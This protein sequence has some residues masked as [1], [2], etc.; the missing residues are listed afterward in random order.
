M[1]WRSSARCTPAS[2]GALR[3]N[4]EMVLTASL[5]RLTLTMHV[6]ASLGWLGALAVFFAHALAGLLSRDD[7]VVRAMALAMAF[8]AWFVILPLSL[9]SLASGLVQAL[10]TAWGLLRHYWIAFK[11]LLTAVATTVLLLKLAP[12]GDLA[13]AAAQATFSHGDQVGLRMSLTM[14][15][16]GG[17]LILLAAAALAI[18]KPA[19][20]IGAGRIPRW[21]KVFGAAAGMLVVLVVAMVVAGG[22]GPSAHRSM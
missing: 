20:T 19:G 22:H 6:S 18:Y 15:A 13:D 9:A 7:Q 10:G 2:S 8:T 4:A 17:L 11:L 16:A 12:I 21:V 14:H 3:E 5:R 1:R